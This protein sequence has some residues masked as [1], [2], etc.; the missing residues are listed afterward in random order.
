MVRAN[1]V[2]TTRTLKGEALDA[3]AADLER[4]ERELAVLDGLR[5]ADRY[6]R[7]NHAMV[8]RLDVSA[9]VA[10][11]V[12]DFLAEDTPVSVV[13]QALFDLIQQRADDLETQAARIN[14]IAADFS[15]LTTNGAA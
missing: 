10:L 8:G 5:G 13:R 3:L 12:L 2:F 15:G 4:T 11:R 9:T 7:A 14:Q 6:L 1:R